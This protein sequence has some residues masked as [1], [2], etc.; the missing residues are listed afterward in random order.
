MVQTK[1]SANDVIT[2]VI[3][4]TD[5]RAD[6]TILHRAGRS[7]GMTECGTVIRWP[8]LL[9]MNPQQ[10]LRNRDYYR[11]CRKCTPVYAVQTFSW[12]YARKEQYGTKE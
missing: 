3:A 2:F 9:S 1:P 11:P 6:E 4:Q 8:M 7:D 10:Y 5:R 12:E